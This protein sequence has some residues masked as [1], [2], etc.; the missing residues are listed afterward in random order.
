MFDTSESVPNDD[1]TSQVSPAL[2]D[3]S[4]F[5]LRGT[6]TS[7]WT[8]CVFAHFEEFLL[9]HA[10]CERK[11]AANALSMVSRYPDRRELVDAMIALAREELEHFQAV[12]DIIHARGLTLGVDKVDDYVNIMLKEC[13]HGRDERLLDRLLVAAMVEARSHERLEAL[14]AAMPANHPCAP[15]M[16]RLLA[17]ESGHRRIFVRLAERYFPRNAVAAALERFVTAEATAF[18]SQPIRP[19]FH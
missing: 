16:E 4:R 9:D 6:T 14:V 10:S 7:E 3:L 18:A 19:G 12:T 13:R 5:Q 15:V 11:A 17:A 2:A 8:D 1:L